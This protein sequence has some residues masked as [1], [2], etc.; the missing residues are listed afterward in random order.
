MDDYKTR[1]LKQE[2]TE[3]GVS[4]NVRSYPFNEVCTLYTQQNFVFKTSGEKALFCVFYAC[5]F[6]TLS[7]TIS[8]ISD[9]PPFWAE[10][11]IN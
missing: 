1:T 10:W 2:V 5:I 9:R 8:Q 11:R 3:N 7:K 4:K 6:I